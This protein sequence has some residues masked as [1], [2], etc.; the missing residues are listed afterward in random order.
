ML[1]IAVHI[2]TEDVQ[3]SVDQVQQRFTETMNEGARS[4]VRLA[5]LAELHIGLR[6]CFPSMEAKQRRPGGSFH[7]P[8][9][10]FFASAA[11]DYGRWVSGGWRNRV[12][13]YRDAALAA[14]SAVHKTRISEDE[15]GELSQLIYTAAGRLA[16]A[17]PDFLVPIGLVNLT[18]NEQGGIDLLVFNADPGDPQSITAEEALA[19]LGE[20]PKQS[21]QPTGPIKLYRRSADLLEYFELWQDDDAV[22]VHKGQCGDRGAAEAITEPNEGARQKL[23][24]ALANQQRLAGF[25]PIPPSRMARLV[26]SALAT[27][28]P[29]TAIGRRHALEKLLNQ[30]LGWLGLG[31]CDGGDIGAGSMEVF[32]EVVDW[33]LANEALQQRLAGTAFADFQVMP[34]Q[35]GQT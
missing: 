12:E 9:K 27:G 15:R 11:I 23:I 5:G 16:E 8:S 21:A 22:I 10:R 33:R 13:A 7:K 3:G 35:K 19:R 32:C 24:R 25:K 28:D 4:L 29:A 1:T 14:L 18:M 30:E 17:P 31:Y 20:L 2:T 26:L 34:Q 6:L